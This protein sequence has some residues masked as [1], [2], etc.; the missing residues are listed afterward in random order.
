MIDILKT[1]VKGENLLDLYCGVGFLGL[2]ISENFKNIYGVEINK[3][4]VLDA[5]K[6]SEINNIYNSYF[7]CGDSSNVSD[8][9]N[10]K[11]DTIIVDPPRTG[12][13]GNTIKYILKFSKKY[14]CVA[15]MISC[16]FANLENVLA[17]KINFYSALGLLQLCTDK[18]NKL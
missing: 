16:F 17:A 10:N 6:N 15:I 8:K 1:N 9:I 7:I 14:I 18:T 11:I 12:L 2:S 13:F 4:S 3:N 5:I